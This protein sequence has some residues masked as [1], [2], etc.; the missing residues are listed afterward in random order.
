[1]STTTIVVGLAEKTVVDWYNFLR[2]ECSSKLMRIPMQ[3]KLIGG[4]GEIVEVDES[5]M[6]KRKHNR[7]YLR[8][9]HEQW[10]FGMY[11]RQRRIGWIEFVDRRD[12]PTLLPVIQRYV[13][14]GTMIYSDGW[15]AYNNLQNIGYGHESVIHADNF[16]DPVT[17]V[18]TN[19]VEAYWSRAKQKIKAVYGW[20][21]HMVPS[22]LDEFLWRERFGL[23]TA[24][25]FYNMLAHIAEHYN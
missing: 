17:G 20:R 11:D 22:Y 6:I 18:H 12:A 15:G 19:G 24:E 4:I 5:Q 7:G 3:D 14:P 8:E 10:V 16:V 13:R 23:Q 1:M 9:Q 25:A 21:L 2:E